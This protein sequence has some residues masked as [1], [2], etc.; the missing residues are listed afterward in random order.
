MTRPSHPIRRIESEDNRFFKQVEKA[1]TGRGIRKYDAVLISGARMVADVL[2]LSPESC[3]AWISTPKLSPPPPALPDHV[4]WYELSPRLFQRLDISGTGT[5][6]LLIQ[7]PSIP[8]WRPEEGFVPGCSVLVPFQDPENV[9][10]VIRSAV[11]FGA[12]RVILLAEAAH[13]YHPKALRAS[14]GAVFMATLARGPSVSEL[15]DTL[16][17]VSLSSEGEDI[18]GFEFPPRFGLLPGVEGPGLPARFRKRAVAIPMAKNVESLN[19]A[20]AAA[21]ALY[22]WSRSHTKR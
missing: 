7:T 18:A 19:A 2:R 17:I 11:A 1:L 8:P 4:A 3:E 21:I 22:L 16:P 10:A 20:T 14:G 9:G 12:K 6:L 13:P 15:P 5:P